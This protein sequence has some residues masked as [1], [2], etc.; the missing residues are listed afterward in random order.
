MALVGRQVLRLLRTASAALMVCAAAAAF[1][2]ALPAQTTPSM[3]SMERA[4]PLPPPQ[5]TLELPPQGSLQP[6]PPA[7]PAAPVLQV[8]DIKIEGNRKH[9]RETVL[10]AMSTRIGHP[11]EQSA[12]ERD[13]RKLTSKSWFVHVVPRKDYVPGGI[14]ITLAVVERPVLEYVHYLG[15][16]RMKDRTLA[17]KSGLKKGDPF[18]PY[19]VREGARKL[20]TFYQSKGF[21]DASVEVPEGT[22]P[23]DR[24]A[25]YLIHEGQKLK[26]S[27]IS[28][29]GNSRAIA[30]DGRL[31]KV[32]ESREPFLFFFKG[33]VDRNKIKRDEEKL[34]LYYRSLGFFKARVGSDY[35]Y[36]EDEDRMKL[37]FYIDEGVRYNVRNVSFIGNHVYPEEALGADLQLKSGD[38]Y[39]QSKMQADI[40]ALKDLYGSNGYVFADANADLRFDLEPGVVDLIYKIEEGQQWRIGDITVTI[41]GDNP[42]TKHSTILNQL[43]MRP[44]DIADIRQFRAGERRIKASGLFNMDP[45]KGEL[46]SITFRLPEWAEAVAEN[47]QRDDV[48]QASGS[49]S[50]RGQSPDDDEPW[51]VTPRSTSG[52]TTTARQPARRHQ[53]EAGRTTVRGQSPDNTAGWGGSHVK[54]VSPG[55]SSFAVNPPTTAQQRYAAGGAQYGPAVGY[56]NQARYDAPVQPGPGGQVTPAQYAEPA[57]DPLSNDTIP[58]SGGYTPRDFGSAPEVTPPGNF[59]G[60]DGM[61]GTQPSLPI[62]VV[63]SEGQTGRFMLGAG[64]NSNAGLVGSI[65]L[66][67][68]NFDWRRWPTSWEDFRSGRAFRGAGQKLRIEAAPG[69][70]VQRYLFNFSEPFLF[71]TPVS[72]G[73]SG[74]YFNR[75]YLNWTEQ[76]LGGRVTL[77]YQFTPDFSGSLG[78]RAEDV[79]LPAS[80]FNPEGV[81]D[82]DE[83][84]GR[85]Q[86]YS[87]RGSL[88]HDTRDSTFLPTE[89]HY[90][91]TT[92]EYFEGTFQYPWFALNFQQHWLLRQRPD[93]TGRHT[94]SYYNQLG[95]AGS[96]TPVYERFFAGGFSTLRGFQFR[97]ASPR[98]DSLTEPGESAIVGGDF[99]FLNSVEYM[100]PV[101]ADDML[102]M[103][104]FV[105]FGTVEESVAMTWDEFRIAPGAGIRVT[106]PAISAAPIAVDFAVPVKHAEGDLIQN[107]SFFVGVA[108]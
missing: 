107:V 32:I 65:V 22:K 93:G 20:E 53:R 60:P 44:G 86:L 13:V 30:P 54:P 45:S 33:E 23:G 97:G 103:V 58:P 105:D 57:Q 70:E 25:V 91:T 84:A 52:T 35:E 18:G 7:R 9:S 31:K 87:A 49:S 61:P 16:Q 73:L 15:N 90:I 82:L 29:V 42:H 62:D 21:S 56:S 67:E 100:F 46:P 12:F 26:F 50:V 34:E 80:S 28:F 101:T 43:G 41:K 81:P 69:T 19:A 106:I 79:L 104:A 2:G 88:A 72:F 37:V 5:Q 85:T 47:P 96:D 3:A 27:D 76:R 94:L 83:A 6:P 59:L 78:L 64:V 102:K 17:K 99:Q 1:P 95:F 98:Q 11:F 75:I 74:Y 71:D 92:F 40:G 36:N 63:A 108:R 10:N 55:P 48:R 39:D 24:G 66:D 68:Q 4:T 77:G 14:I 89:G 8:V 38:A 51:S